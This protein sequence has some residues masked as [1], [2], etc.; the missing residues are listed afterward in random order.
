MNTNETNEKNVKF[1]VVYQTRWPTI[2]FENPCTLT[3]SFYF[4]IFINFSNVE[5]SN[6]S[7]KFICAKIS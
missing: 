1:I 7:S 4:S 6:F 3:Y 5:I 2:N